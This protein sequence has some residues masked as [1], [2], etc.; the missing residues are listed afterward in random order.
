MKRL[1]GGFVVALV[2]LN[3]VPAL[4]DKS[5]VPSDI[6]QPQGTVSV[7]VDDGSYSSKPSFIEVS[8]VTETWDNG[9]E[10]WSALT[11]CEAL[12]KAPCDESMA[13]NKSRMVFAQLNMPTCDAETRNFCIEGVAIYQEGAAADAAS[14]IR[15]NAGPTVPADPE[16]NLPQGSPVSLWSGTANHTGGAATYAVQARGEFRLEKGK[17]TLEKI[18]LTVFPY[19]EVAKPGEQGFFWEIKDDGNRIVQGFPEGFAFTDKDLVGETHNFNLDTRVK[20][21]LRV[22]SEVKG[23]LKGRAT[24]P[25]FSST[26]INKSTNR[27]VLDAKPVVV[28]KL[29]VMATDDQRSKRM[30]DFPMWSDRR[31]QSWDNLFTSAE[32]RDA[33]EWIKDLRPLAK[34]TASAQAVVWQLSATSWGTGACDSKVNGISGFVLTNAMAYEG[35]AP[36]YQRG[37]LNYKVAG[38]HNLADGTE[39]IGT[40]DL[41]MNSAVARCLYGFNKAPVSGTITIS[42]DGDKNIATTVVSEKNGWLKLAAYGFTFSEKTLKVKL[43]QK[44]Q[45]TITCVASG[46]KS[47]KVTA[48]SPKC[49][50]GYKKR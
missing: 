32:G 34:D 26:R 45:T 4:A 19:L 7:T 37:F 8:R 14:F 38:M 25:N 13:T 42:G 24:E 36:A 35:N 11:Q 44:K 9:K 48:A 43:T 28:P 18:D 29:R 23:W 47:V 1:I 46:K 30:R 2:L 31:A 17:F 40:Y 12:D 16:R 27:F 50:K 20:L 33:F 15:Y 39:A 21:S 22:P 3:G 10:M 49:P 5:Y 6:V 41:V